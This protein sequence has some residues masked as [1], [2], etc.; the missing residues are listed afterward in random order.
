MLRLLVTFPLA[1]AIC[2][3]LFSMMAW[4]VDLNVK[5]LREKSEPLLFDI[6]AAEPDQIS[7]RKSR[8]LP[9]PPERKPEPPIQQ[10]TLPT[11]HTAMSMPT[12]EPL[13]DVSL[14][15]SVTGVAITAPSIPISKSSVQNS[16]TPAA[17]IADIGQTQAVLPLHRAE[18]VYPHDA[19]RRRIQGHVTLSFDIDRS[20]KPMN[21]KIVEANPARI[22]NR[23]AINALRRWKYQPQIIN[24]Q[25]Q[26]RLDQKVKLEF[27]LR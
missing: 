19:L 9:P 26:E 18:P 15:M 27:K 11:M 10:Q 2:F 16:P 12:I 6:F 14:S 25:A 24:G 4:M 1:L 8:V 20:G 17:P 22:F 3:S 21:I 13:P 7:Q 23:E 5:P